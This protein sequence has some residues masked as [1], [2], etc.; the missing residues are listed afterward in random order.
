[1]VVGMVHDATSASRAPGV[2][3]ARGCVGRRHSAFA[4]LYCAADRGLHRRAAAA[5]GLRP[6]TALQGCGTAL[7]HAP[8]SC[9]LAVTTHMRDAALG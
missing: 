8:A 5:L 6:R 7:R 3:G 2:E 4:S 1:M 9:T